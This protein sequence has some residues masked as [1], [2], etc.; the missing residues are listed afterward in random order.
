MTSPSFPL[1]LPSLRA[2]YMAGTLSPATV[3]KSL[4][5][6]AQRYR[7]HNIWIHLMSEA[8]IQPYLQALAGKDPAT[9]PLYGVPFAIKDNIDL[10]GIATTAA[11]EAFAY[12]PS[13]SAFVVE[14]L[15]AAGAIPIG[16]TNLDQFA[17]GLVGTRSPAP[18]GPCRNA[19]NPDYISGGSSSGSAVAVALGLVSFS[20]GTDTAGSGRV[21]AMLNNI[22]G[23]KPSRGLFSTRGVV[24]ACRSLDCPT[25]FGLSAAD[26]QAVFTVAAKP[27]SEDCYSRANPYANSRRHWGAPRKPPRI[28]IPSAANLEF[29]GDHQA[30]QLFAAAVQRWREHGATIVDTDISALLAAA[31]LL[32]AG[33]WV[34]ERYAGIK[35]FIE[36]KPQQMHPVVHGII[37]GATQF[38]AVQTYHA[39]Y[40]MQAYR[41]AAQALLADVDFLMTPTAPTAYTID[42]VLNDP[43]T[44]NSRMGYYTNYLNLLDLSGIAV[45]AGLLASGVGFGVTLIAPAFRDQ[46]LLSHAHQWQLLRASAVGAE[47]FIPAL[48]TVPVLDH[49]TR[50]AVAVCGAHLQ[51]MPLNWQLTERGGT[52]LYAGKSSAHYRLYALAGPGIAR[53]GL[54]RDTSNGAAIEIEVWSLPRSEFGDF[55]ANIPAPLGIGKME[56]ENG[57]WVCGFICEPCGI[58][59]A[60]DITHFG[61]WRAYM[62]SRK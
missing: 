43:V 56:T 34:A 54:V 21:P 62:Q 14:Q 42:A 6:K 41:K 17:T 46:L 22:Y 9:L 50:V 13:R 51:H 15:L 52:L 8:E 44:L 3:V 16:K 33:P 57:E 20:L 10:A 4:L 30:E 58:A 7:S 37:S 12:T 45:P 24:P 55:V 26:L 27:D 38:S 2:A 35:D 18:W 53:P 29:F 32:Y 59:D 31:K 47:G 39:E 40:Q 36:Q 28:A 11:C 48:P 5:A 49:N 25:V 60:A 1:D 19:L 61:G 23:L